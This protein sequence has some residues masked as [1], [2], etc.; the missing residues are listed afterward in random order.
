MKILPHHEQTNQGLS[1]L[2]DRTSL[3]E[4]TFRSSMFDN[5]LYSS[6]SEAQAAY[7]PVQDIVN[8]AASAYEDVTS[9]SEPEAAAEYL[10]EA[11]E[12]VAMQSVEEQPQDLK[13][14]REDWNEIKEELEEYGL[15]KK[16]IADLEEKVMS[17]NGI[18]YG[19]LVSELSGMMKGMK[20]ITLSPIQEQNLNS[21]FSQLG[22]TPD[23]SKGL[24]ASIRQGKLG[25]V[26]EKMQAKLASMPDS[27]K[28]QLSED[29]T[30]T[31]TDLFKLKGDTGK[32]ITQL[33]TAEGATAA[34]F[35]K[36]F[37]VLKS[38]LAQQ[39]AEQDGKDLKLVKTVAESLHSAMEK[40]SDQSP[41]TMRMAS[42]DVISNSM[43]A[44]KE[45]SESV[46]QDGQNGQ[47]GENPAQKD[48]NPS[49]NG[50]D[51]KGDAN[52]GKQNA[53]QTEDKNSNRHWL[54]QLLSDSD[55]QDSWNDFFG[56]LTDE[57]FV[58]GEGNLNGN[59]F[60]NGFGTLQSAVKSAQAGKTD[61][62]W[63]KTARSNIL[64]QVQEG[65]FK[66]LGQ[67]RKQLTLQLNPHNLG[68][69]NVMLQVK[70]K[71]VQAT[72]RA[73]NPDTA[74]VIAEQLEVV[75]QALEEQGLKVEKLE[76]QTGIS[77]SQTDSSW[78]NAEDHNAAQYQE[79][80]SEMRK[81]WQTLRQ[82]GS[83]LAREMQTVQQK[84]QISQSGL[85][86]V[87]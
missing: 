47:N 15:D 78:K 64:E 5:F 30:K 1:N 76:V 13:V 86:I 40:A 14:S 48:N 71:D 44:A 36:G 74:K 45:V 65:V 49:K 58:K 84:A 73:E 43:G 28:L 3:S 54:E 10:D 52:A 70:N 82:E 33:L 81:R 75:K 6:Q 80:M 41:S 34:D 23:E 37:S 61:L 2:L 69:V 51:L 63:E 29:E 39:Q 79:M 77:D 22:F 19:Q 57:S 9:R 21:I 59:I 7:Q 62:M 20:G 87:A 67:G 24:L 35:K 72:I 56:K 46:K 42:A 26:V 83:S 12:K 38:A 32:K 60:G 17:E 55:D 50:A 53:G 16:D 85:Y 27:E 66:N 8:E 31:L 68:T 4:D 18:T 25:D 11:A